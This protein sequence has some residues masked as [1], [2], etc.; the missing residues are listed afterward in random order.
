MPV[1]RRRAPAACEDRAVLA[2]AALQSECRRWLHPA[3]CR[4]S[5]AADRPRAQAA[6]CRCARPLRAAEPGSRAALREPQPEEHRRDAA[7]QPPSGVVQA[8]A[9]RHGRL[10]ASRDAPRCR[11]FSVAAAS[12][13]PA[14]TAQQEHPWTGLFAGKGRRPRTPLCDA[15]SSL[16][17]PRVPGRANWRALLPRRTGGRPRP[18]QPAVPWRRRL[19]GWRAAR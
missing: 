18:R 8:V 17:V 11:A 19:C 5:R 15:R 6:R 9:G 3:G 1:G 16:P 14:D 2:G 13:V 7:P 4:R 10:H 12:G